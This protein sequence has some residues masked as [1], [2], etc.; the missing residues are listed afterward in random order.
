MT[1]PRGQ[2]RLPSFLNLFQKVQQWNVLQTAHRRLW[3]ARAAPQAGPLETAEL[4]LKRAHRPLHPKVKRSPNIPAA[5]KC[6]VVDESCVRPRVWGSP[7]PQ[8]RWA[9]PTLP[10]LP[11]SP[12]LCLLPSKFSSLFCL[13]LPSSFSHF[14]SLF[15]KAFFGGVGVGA[16]TGKCSWISVSSSQACLCTE[17]QASQSYIMTYLLKH[18]HKSGSGGTWL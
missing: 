7:D 14:L 11:A 8:H 1:Q 9:F 17:F 2:W 3:E 5:S 15:L 13:T 16:E 10:S 18:H 6:P 12:F 4:S